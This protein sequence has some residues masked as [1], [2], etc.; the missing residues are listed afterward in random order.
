MIYLTG[1]P[2]GKP[3]GSWREPAPLLALGDA[4]Y[5]DYNRPGRIRKDPIPDEFRAN[6]AAGVPAGHAGGAR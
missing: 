1:Q 5:S 2:G 6:S 3:A 4:M